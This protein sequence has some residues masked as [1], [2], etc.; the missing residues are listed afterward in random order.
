MMIMITL[1]LSNAIRAYPTVR[2]DS[3]CSFSTAS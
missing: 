3:A 2:L 1:T